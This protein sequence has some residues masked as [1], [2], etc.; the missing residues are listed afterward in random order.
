M[1]VNAFRSVIDQKWWLSQNSSYWVVVESN[2]GSNN[3]VVH[4]GGCTS[5]GFSLEKAAIKTFPYFAAAKGMNSVA[6]AMVVAQHEDETYYCVMD[7]KSGK[8]DGAADQIETAR[9]FF[10]WSLELA[11]HHG[12]CG[13][14]HELNKRFFGVINMAPRNQPR[15]GLSRRS[16]EIPPPIKSPFGNYPL[17][18]LKNHPKVSLPEMIKLVQAF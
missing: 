6:D 10:A 18:M 3:K 1:G 2:K 12:H 11:K 15:K 7:L 14:G 13:N 16:A 5:L 9:M 17:F 4:I 8:P